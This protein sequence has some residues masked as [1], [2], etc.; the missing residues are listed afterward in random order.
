MTRPSMAD[1]GGGAN[2]FTISGRAASRAIA[3]VADDRRSDIV[4]FRQRPPVRAR[5]PRGGRNVYLSLNTPLFTFFSDPY[6]KYRLATASAFSEYSRNVCAAASIEKGKYGVRGRERRKAKV[7]ERAAGEEKKLK[8]ELIKIL[9]LRERRSGQNLVLKDYIILRPGENGYSNGG[10]GVE[11]TRAC[12]TFHVRR[13]THAVTSARRQ[14]AAPLPHWALWARAQ[15]PAIEWGPLVPARLPNDNRYLAQSQIAGISKPLCSNFEKEI[16]SESDYS[17]DES[18]T[19]L[20]TSLKPTTVSI[21]LQFS[22]TEELISHDPADYF[23]EKFI[24]INREILIR[25]GP[26]YFQNKDSDFSEASRTY[27]DEIHDIPIKDCRG[28]SYDNAS[29][30]SGKYSGLQT[31]I[32]EKCE[33]ATF[34]PCAGHSLNLVGVHAAGWNMLTEH[35]GS[36]KVV[37]SLSQTRWSARAD[38]VSALHGGYKRIIEALITIANDTEQ[39]RETRNEALSLSRKMRNLEFIILT[40]IWSSILERI[41][42]TS[43][44]LQKETITLDV[45][46]N[47]FTSLHDFITN[48]RDKFD[49]FESSA[50]EKNPESDYKDLSQ[51]TRRRSSRQSFFDGSAPS[52]QLNGKERF[53]VETFLPII[54]TL[55]VHLKQR[56]SSYETFACRPA[57]DGAPGPVGFRVGGCTCYYVNALAD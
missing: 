6:P 4:C 47:L 18:A 38:A 19:T 14:M 3:A 49:N 54:D 13:L 31:R 32:K 24:E 11:C 57:H 17:Y 15:G 55:S 35:L 1:Y 45:A 21:E 20:V 12:L 26:V 30:M 44:Y 52:V 41:D 40:E 56:L 23:H 29:N 53:N 43:N 36:K 37:K 39:A 50:K 33:F 7:R 2:H 5:R 27:K 22:N 46:T 51:R 9:H 42:K 8:R 34:V 16:E 48:L 10:A 25:E 28:Q